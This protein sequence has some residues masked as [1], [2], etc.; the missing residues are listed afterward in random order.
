MALFSGLTVNLGQFLRYIAFGFG[1][2]IVV[3]MMLRTIP[4]W[5]LFFAFIFIRKYESFSRW[6][7]IGNALIMVGAVLVLLS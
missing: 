2:V 3:S 5:V 7:L 1:S 6:V 4:L